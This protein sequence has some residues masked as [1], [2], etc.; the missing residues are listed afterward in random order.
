MTVKVNMVLDDDVK[1]ELDRLVEAG[2]RS[3]VVNRALRAE[4]LAIRRRQ[5]AESLDQLR[6]KTRAV[7]ARDVL[8]M[9]RKDRGRK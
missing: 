7:A 2:S 8:R 3:R 5:A 6:A 9:L 4:L 1:A